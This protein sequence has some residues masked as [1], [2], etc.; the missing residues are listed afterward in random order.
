MKRHE[1][2]TI[3]DETNN[4]PQMVEE[5]NLA[6]DIV[7]SPVAEETRRQCFES[8]WDAICDNPE[9][10]LAMRIRSY[11]LRALGREIKRLGQNPET[12]CQHLNITNNRLDDI[13]QGRIDRLS[14]D[15]LTGMCK[16]IGLSVDRL[17]MEVM[18]K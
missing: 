11:L 10:S 5:N 13:L 3:C 9:E 16:R 15:Q 4:P 7:V 8:V 17:M 2:I 18:E 6:L 12:I 1:W 14:R